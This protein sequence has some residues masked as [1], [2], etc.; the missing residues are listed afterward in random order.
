MSEM[1]RLFVS[2]EVPVT[3]RLRQAMADLDSVKGVRASKP[4][5]IHITLCFL[6]DTDVR[7]IPEL[8]EN[9]KDALADVH[10]F[11][12]KVKGIGGFPNLKRP[13]V[14]WAG[15]DDGGNLAH[16]A[17]KVRSAVE[18]THLDF[19]GKRFSP[20]VT[21]ARVQGNADIGGIG[22][23]Y[24]DTVFSESEVD[25]VRLMRSV[26]SPSGAKHTVVERIPLL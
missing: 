8:A 7:R 22:E 6:G 13:R 19:D 18:R 23:R 15:T 11:C 3:D 2:V 4:E 24:D 12:L 26:L 17:D 10:R 9:L 5:Q 1:A 20:H 14:V 16:L 25:S 21:I